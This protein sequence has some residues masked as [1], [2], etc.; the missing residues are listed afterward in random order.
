MAFAQ[1]HC[2]QRPLDGNLWVYVDSNGALAEL[3]ESDS[4][5]IANLYLTNAVDENLVRAFLM[6][7]SSA[8]DDA[9]NCQESVGNFKDF[10]M[11]LLLITF[12]SLGTE[13]FKNRDS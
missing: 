9:L 13:N 7:I 1:I 5:Y 3:L 10:D 12:S 2:L 11:G 6:P 8:W 4:E